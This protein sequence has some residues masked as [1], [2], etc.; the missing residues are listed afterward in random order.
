MAASPLQSFTRSNEIISQEWL[1][2]GFKFSL[3]FRSVAGF[4]TEN[5][6]NL[7]SVFHLS[8]KRLTTE[9]GQ[10]SRLLGR[11]LGIETIM[12]PHNN[13]WEVSASWK[14]WLIPSRSQPQ[15]CRGFRRRSSWRR[16]TGEVSLCHFPPCVPAACGIQ[17]GKT[18]CHNVNMLL[19]LS[20]KN[21]CSVKQSPSEKG[22]R[23]VL[24]PGNHSAAA[25]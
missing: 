4:I 19:D 9:T 14:S 23:S 17:A 7:S 2:N 5:N 8:L 16:A 18:Q 25:F 24:G 15:P 11:T 13:L 6:L 10:Q 3:V 12:L 22:W 1:E 20:L 21:G